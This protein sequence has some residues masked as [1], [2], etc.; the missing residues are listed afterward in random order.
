MEV[1]E[2]E[3]TQPLGSHCTTSFV[4]CTNTLLV[5]VTKHLSWE[6]YKT[7]KAIFS[8]RTGG[9]ALAVCMASGT[10][11][12]AASRNGQEH[13]AS[14][15]YTRHTHTHKCEWCTHDEASPIELAWEQHQPPS[16]QERV[17]G[18]RASRTAFQGRLYTQ[19]INQDHI[20]I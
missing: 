3:R 12:G 15:A 14:D 9:M 8:L 13:G 7:Q 11:L 18:N 10:D 19:T 2:G 5:I 17:I 1:S 20:S 4:W 16:S 6:V